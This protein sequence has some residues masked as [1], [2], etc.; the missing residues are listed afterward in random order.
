MRA[1]VNLA[2]LLQGRDTKA[3]QLVCLAEVERGGGARIPLSQS[4]LVKG[5]GL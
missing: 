1:D 3:G 4:S 2:S 5:R